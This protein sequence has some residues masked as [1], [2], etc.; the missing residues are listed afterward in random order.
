MDDPFMCI[1]MVLDK[2]LVK[3][4]AWFVAKTIAVIDCAYQG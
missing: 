1:T 4:Q 2:F 3:Y